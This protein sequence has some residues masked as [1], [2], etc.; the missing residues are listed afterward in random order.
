[1]T[2]RFLTRITVWCLVSS[3][4][5][6]V[7]GAACNTTAPAPAQP[8]APEQ[9]PLPAQNNPPANQFPPVGNVPLEPPP[10]T[11]PGAIDLVGIWTSAETTQYGTVYAE[12]ILE[13]NNNYSHQVRWGDLMTYEVGVYQA[14]DGFIHFSVQDYQ[15]KEYKGTA[16]SRPLSWTVYFTVVDENT[17]TW[18][19]RIMNTRWQVH[20]RGK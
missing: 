3:T 15:P 2:L 4:L 16:L 10:D 11:A 5:A 9:Q 12:T 13:R 18:E 1:M 7:L 6:I 20:R 19:D 17:M 8:Q 14:G